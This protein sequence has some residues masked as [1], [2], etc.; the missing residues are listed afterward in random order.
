M[1]T[2][3][4]RSILLSLV[5]AMTV[6]LFSAC[7]SGKTAKTENNS[8][9]SS[10]A[11]TSDNTLPIVKDKLTLTYWMPLETKYSA[12]MK[13]INDMEMSKELEKRTG[14]HIEYQH[15]VAGQET[16]Q[17]NLMIA[18][19]DLP[20][21]L[22]TNWMGK[23]G[24]PDK[25][26]QDGVIIDMTDLVNKYAPNYKSMLEKTPQAVKELTTRT[27]K[28]YMMS[29]VYEDS[30]MMI[31]QGLQMRKDW[32]DKLGLKVPETISDWYTTLKAIKEKDPNGNGKADEI[33]LLSLGYKSNISLIDNVGI[34][35]SAWGVGQD[36]YS[37]DDGKV[38]FGP[39]QPEFKEFLKEMNKWYKEGLIDPDFATTDK[40]MFDSKITEG[41]AG[42]W[43]AGLM[44]DMG[45]YLTFFKS[46]NPP[47]AVIA[48]PYP[49]LSASGKAYNMNTNMNSRIVTSG[50]SITKANKHPVETVKWFDYSYSKEGNLLYNYGIEG[51]TYNVV[52]GKIEFTDLVLKNP[53]G[54]DRTTALGH[55]CRGAAATGAHNPDLGIF[56]MRAYM[57]EQLDAKKKIWKAASVDH[58]LPNLVPEESESQKQASILTEVY[59]YANEAITKMVMGAEPIDNFDKFVDTLKK[60]KID[61]ATA[62]KQKALDDFKS[63]K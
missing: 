38:K 17:F 22:E 10:T 29:G 32:L 44:G 51:L 34:F 39:I 36:Y 21:I 12:T 19:G 42:A 35:A 28:H 15:P 40:K 1:K 48:A 2:K 46:Q 31:M 25:A 56:D 62:I 61:E 13:N 24:G 26:L 50:C 11:S 52:N 7:G 47:G 4:N 20:D 58:T 23:P 53:Q 54:W 8:G 27:G 55:Y 59:T 30:E 6:S 5:A 37:A 63:K 60:M 45:K 57:P 49:K 43:S 9:S 16:T 33:P 3:F 18:S 41:R 14:I